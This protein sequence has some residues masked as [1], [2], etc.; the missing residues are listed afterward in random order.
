MQT[1]AIY[2]VPEW[3]SGGAPD[4]WTTIHHGICKVQNAYIYTC[5]DAVTSPS[6]VEGAIHAPHSFSELIL[7]N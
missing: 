4:G 3:G 5:T 6:A 7:I 2:S 1:S